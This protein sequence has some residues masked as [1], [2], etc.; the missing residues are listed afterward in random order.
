MTE[1]LLALVD[2]GK[3]KQ[4]RK[5]EEEEDVVD[6]YRRAVSGVVDGV[7]EDAVGAERFWRRSLC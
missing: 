4:R 6:G 7:L 5:L 3:G 1:K 2:T